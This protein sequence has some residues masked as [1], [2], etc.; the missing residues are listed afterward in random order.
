MYNNTLLAQQHFCLY[1]I[2]LFGKKCVKI[3]WLCVPRA[4][5]SGQN[6]DAISLVS[7]ALGVRVVLFSSEGDEISETDT[8]F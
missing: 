4:L 6:P 8:L 1:V 7:L 5:F 3:L 2:F